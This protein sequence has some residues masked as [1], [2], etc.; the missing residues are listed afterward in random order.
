MKRVIVILVAT[1]MFAGC[2]T[3]KQLSEV[4]TL[5]IVHRGVIHKPVIAD[6]IVEQERVVGTAAARQ[7][8]DIETLKILAIQNAL[9]NAGNADILVDPLFTVT[10]GGGTTVEV[11]GY[12]ARYS[13]F[14]SME[15]S[16]IEWMRLLP[17]LS[18]VNVVE[19][20][21]EPKKS[22]NKWLPDMR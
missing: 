7:A 10:E 13:N 3:T 15:D 20:I 9:A 21:D 8:P 22:N 19:K 17:L 4:K 18:P 11:R 1:A 14:R 12:P 6:L 16:D 2:S 5:D